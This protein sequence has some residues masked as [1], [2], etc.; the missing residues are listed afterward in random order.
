MDSARFGRVLG[1][2]T[3]LAA[4]TLVNAVD[5]AASPNPSG[6]HA[7]AKAAAAGTAQHVAQATVRSANQVMQ[8]GQE[9]AQGGRRFGESFWGLVKR[10]SGVLWLEFT[11]VFFGIFAVYSGSGAW[12]LRGNLRET[13]GNHDAHVHLLLAAAMSVLFGYFCVTSFW[14]AGRRGKAR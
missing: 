9:L 6:A 2:G 11:G 13:A 4:K 12:K 3:R 7:N 14:R 5:A 1:I 10:L 8:T